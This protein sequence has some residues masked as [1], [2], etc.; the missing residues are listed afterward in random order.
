[1]QVWTPTSVV[2]RGSQKEAD[3]YFDYFAVKHQDRESVDGLISISAPEVRNMP[4]EA[5]EALRTRF[6]A[7]FGGF[8]LVGTAERIFERLNMLSSAGLDGV[9]LTWV[10]YADGVERFNR[11]VLPL[12]E[13]AGFRQPFAGLSSQFAGSSSQ[14]ASA[15]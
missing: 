2:Q 3:D 1:V 5:W 8:P 7:G 4:P 10:D 11:D 14:T 12:L 6:A 9:L 13:Q 15:G